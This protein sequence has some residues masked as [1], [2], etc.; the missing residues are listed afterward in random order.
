MFSLNGFYD[1]AIKDTRGIEI[2]LSSF[3]GKKVL[4]VNTASN[5]NY[6][7]QYESLERLY[8]QYKNQLVIIA[9]PSNDFGHEPEDNAGIQSFVKSHYDVH[10]ILSEKT[11]VFGSAKCQVYQWLTQ[12]INNGVIN[13]EVK[14]DFYKFLIDE[15]GNLVGVFSP[16]VDPMSDELRSVIPN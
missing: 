1:Y 13:N 8:Q 10:F 6:V 12:N 3:R 14:T 7:N 9:F 11:N 5:S 4:L 15:S 2:Q 16:S